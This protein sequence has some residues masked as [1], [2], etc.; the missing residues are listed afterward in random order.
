MP[1]NFIKE[2]IKRLIIYKVVKAVYSDYVSS[3]FLSYCAVLAAI[4]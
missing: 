4:S 2:V 3:E 1:T